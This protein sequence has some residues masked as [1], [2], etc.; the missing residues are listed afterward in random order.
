MRLVRWLLEQRPWGP[1]YEA[2]SRNEGVHW[3]FLAMGTSFGDNQYVVVVKD[4]LTHYCELFPTA[5]CDS[6][7]AATGLPE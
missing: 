3:D 6:M 1:T 2:K 7:D 4:V 5:S